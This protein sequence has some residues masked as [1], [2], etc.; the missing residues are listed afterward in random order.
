MWGIGRLAVRSNERAVAN[1]RGAATALGRARVER[2]EVEVFLA[3]S[4]AALYVCIDRIRT[5]TAWDRAEHRRQRRDSRRGS[6]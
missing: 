2:V 1:A 5:L 4:L 3:P 6:P